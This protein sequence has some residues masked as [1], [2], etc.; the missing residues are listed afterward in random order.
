MLVVW[1]VPVLRRDVH[2][3]GH[4]LSCRCNGLAPGPQD[5]ARR[6]SMKGSCGS[7]EELFKRLVSQALGKAREGSKTRPRDVGRGAA[8]CGRGPRGGERSA[9]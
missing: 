9:A 7:R 8:S 6:V 5:R 3:D 2:V 1:P 4:D